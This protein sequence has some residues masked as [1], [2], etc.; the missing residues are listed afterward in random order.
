M[1]D[2]FLLLLAGG[3]IDIDQM[4]EDAVAFTVGLLQAPRV[5]VSA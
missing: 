2:V 3:T 1:S 4:A 5:D